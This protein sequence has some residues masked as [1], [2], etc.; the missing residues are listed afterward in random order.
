MFEL[1]FRRFNEKIAISPEEEEIIK[2]YLIH[3]KIRRN[4]YL[5][6]SGDI[7]KHIVFVEKGTLKAYIADTAGLVHIT[8]FAL[9]GQNF[10]D[11]DSFINEKPSSHNI[12]AIE[13]SELILISKF[14]HEEL[15]RDMPKYETFVRM[16]MTDD[17]LAL[18]RRTAN[19]ISL[20]L[21]ERYPTLARIHPELIQRLPLHMIAS[22]MGISAET[23]SR[24][25]RRINN[26][27]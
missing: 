18:Q 26:K 15:L 12:D 24:V 9:E 2:S 6:Q 22:Y 1:F 13:D 21:E 23:L 4:Q 25:R 10:V 19:M 7:C 8:A 11:M 14:A 3:K 17:Y 16:L 20:S 27:T 5:L